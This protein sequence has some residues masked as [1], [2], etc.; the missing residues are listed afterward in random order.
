MSIPNEALQKL[1]QEIEVQ[2]ITSQQQIGVTKAQITTKQRD[3]RMLELTSK[4]IG[5]LPKDTRVYEGV[6]KMF[7]AVPMNTIDKRLS[8]ESGEL[9]TDIAG[10][11]KKLHYLEMTHKNSRENLEQILKSGGKA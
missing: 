2:A 4:E 6:G 5:S 11:E 9:K 1:L 7:V 10:L 3:I 8:S